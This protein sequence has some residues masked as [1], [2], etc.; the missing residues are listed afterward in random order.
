MKKEIKK[1]KVT[2]KVAK[3]IKSVAKSTKAVS[4][5]KVAKPAK[6]QITQVEKVTN[7]L[8]KYGKI[9]GTKALSLGITSLPT[10]VFK[11][12]SRG[13]KI[14]SSSKTVKG[15]TVTTYMLSK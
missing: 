11:L 9:T 2:K 1:T 8:N 3:A 7:Y 5:K 6:K 4:T 14:T 15:K 12:R 10:A 13:M